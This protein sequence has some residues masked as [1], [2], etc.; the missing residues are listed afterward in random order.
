MSF[1]NHIDHVDKK[2]KKEKRQKEKKQLTCSV[3][4][5]EFATFDGGAQ[6]PKSSR[7]ENGAAETAGAH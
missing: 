6:V 3:A 7:K 2:D 4:F 5:A 1:E